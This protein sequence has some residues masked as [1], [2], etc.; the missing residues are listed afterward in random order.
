[1]KPSQAIRFGIAAIVLVLLLAACM[2]PS[3]SS[4]SASGSS[5]SESTTGP[6]IEQTT[7]LESPQSP[8]HGNP[9]L[10]LPSPPVGNNNHNVGAECIQIAWLTGPIPHGDV[11]KITS[12]TVPG[13]LFNLDLG[14]TARCQ[15]GQ[16]CIGYQFSELN[17]NNGAFCNVG[18]AYEGEGTVDPPNDNTESGTIV[19]AGR[20]SCPH[21]SSAKCRDDGVVMEAAARRPISFNVG[22]DPAT[23]PPSTSSSS[24]STSSSPSENSSSPTTS[25][26]S[27]P[28]APGSP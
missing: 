25:D 4:S 24:A 8:T 17:D 26:S 3:D 10:S 22:I 28:A 27:S 21:I 15:G 5:T 14:T 6:A 2:H 20:L 19:L 16:S 23:S 9:S 18:V 13:P 1:M 12:V 11:V 7:G